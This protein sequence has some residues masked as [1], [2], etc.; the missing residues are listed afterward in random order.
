MSLEALNLQTNKLVYLPTEI[1]VLSNLRDLNVKDNPLISPPVSVA[2]KGLPEI[3]TFYPSLLSSSLSTL[4]H[5]H[6]FFFFSLLRLFSL[7][8]QQTLLTFFFFQ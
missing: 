4:S 2:Q 5:F 3:G 6:M 7:C 8:P 1:A